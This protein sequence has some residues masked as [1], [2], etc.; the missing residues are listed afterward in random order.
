MS[1]RHF[2]PDELDA[3]GA[4]S[5]H[6]TSKKDTDVRR[7]ELLNLITPPLEKFFEENM[8]FYLTDSNQLL[9]ITLNARIEIGNVDKSDAFDEMIR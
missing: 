9:P 5:E 4:L 1:K 6:T 8:L 7:M 2:T 3:F